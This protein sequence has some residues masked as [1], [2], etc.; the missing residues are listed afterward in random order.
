MFFFFFFL[1]EVQRK[2]KKNCLVVSP[3]NTIY[4]LNRGQLQHCCQLRQHEESTRGSYS[5]FPTL[6]PL[7]HLQILFFPFFFF[8]LCV[9]VKQK[10]PFTKFVFIHSPK[11]NNA[12]ECQTKKKK[13]NKAA[14][15][16]K[17]TQAALGILSFVHLC[18]VTR[19]RSG[20]PHLAFLLRSK[21]N[22]HRVCTQACTCCCRFSVSF[23]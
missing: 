20:F 16:K 5:E 22:R 8:F 15:K 3:M 6:F 14:I 11:W 1:E 12:L 10:A 4:Q 17:K 23:S 13:A 2:K 21:H 7:F 18:K 9:Y 19:T